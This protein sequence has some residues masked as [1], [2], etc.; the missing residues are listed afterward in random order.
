M[1]PR[2][3]YLREDNGY[4]QKQLAEYLLCDEAAYSKF[5]TGERILPLED[6]V[7]LADLYNVSVDY[8]VGR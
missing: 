7:K 6:A 2:L 5:E 1:E 3:K 4:T 8:I